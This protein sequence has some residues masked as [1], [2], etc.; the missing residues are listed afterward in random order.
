M[1]DKKTY[2]ITDIIEIINHEAQNRPGLE[3]LFEEFICTENG[4][5]QIPID[6]KIY[7]FNGRVACIGVISR[8]SP[9]LF[10]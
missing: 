4:E 8:V 2:A 7:C 5:H 10:L 3:F 1:M 9:A 6:Y